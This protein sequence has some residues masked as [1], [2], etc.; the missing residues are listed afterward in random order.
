MAAILYLRNP[1]PTHV[2]VVIVLNIAK[3]KQGDGKATQKID[4]NQ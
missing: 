3:L 1:L 2:V 4:Y